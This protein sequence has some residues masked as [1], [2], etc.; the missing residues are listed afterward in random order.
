MVGDNI[1]NEIN[2]QIIIPMI[3]GGHK[4]GG[5]YVEINST[6]KYIYSN[7]LQDEWKKTICE[8]PKIFL[9]IIFLIPN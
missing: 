5:V 6:L 1:L 4:Y 2:N 3:D 8:L 7:G 9:L